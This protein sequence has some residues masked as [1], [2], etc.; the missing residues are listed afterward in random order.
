MAKGEYRVTCE[1]GAFQQV[2]SGQAGSVI[3]C[4]CGKQISVPR[5]AEL[6]SMAGEDPYAINA[7]Q[8]IRRA[9]NTD[10]LPSS[11]C[12][13][14]GGP[15]RVLVRCRVV[16]ERSFRV[17]QSEEP[18]WGFGSFLLSLV[19][20]LWISG[21]RK[22]TESRGRDT[23]ALLVLSLCHACRSGAG[24]LRRKRNLKRHLK[25]V[26]HYARL[27]KEYRDATIHDITIG[28]NSTTD[29]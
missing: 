20:P 7:V 12:A 15:A 24:N 9:F 6:R 27:F 29:G 14:C 13:C 17:K 5:L 11:D 18:E 25:F 23:E 8:A 19:S 1:C 26:P 21:S 3:A 2:G 28:D 16:C 10:E 22:Q 4:D